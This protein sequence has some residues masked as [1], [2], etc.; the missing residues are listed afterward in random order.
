MAKEKRILTVEQDPNGEDLMLSFPQD[1]L[2]QVNWK[3]GDVIEWH[4]NGDGSW[5]LKRKL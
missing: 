3:V 1:L 4:D 2:D 5:T